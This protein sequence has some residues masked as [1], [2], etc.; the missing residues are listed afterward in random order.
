[1]ISDSNRKSSHSRTLRGSSAHSL[2]W[3]SVNKGKEFQ[4]QKDVAAHCKQINKETDGSPNLIT[5]FRGE[6]VKNGTAKI[7]CRW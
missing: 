7:P 3:D 2:Q 6:P 1:M 5:I 4:I